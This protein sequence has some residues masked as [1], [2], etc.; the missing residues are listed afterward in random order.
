[1]C[2]RASAD[3]T[4][5]IVVLQLKRDN[6]TY[7]QNITDRKWNTIKEN[8]FLQHKLSKKQQTKKSTTY[9]ICMLTCTNINMYVRMYVCLPV[10]LYFCLPVRMYERRYACMNV[11]MYI[12]VCICVCVGACVNVNVYICV[13]M[14]VCIYA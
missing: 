13:G 2:A 11:F 4:R 7:W 1:M 6:N 10:C 14:S 3:D 12:C 8:I 9:D 5:K